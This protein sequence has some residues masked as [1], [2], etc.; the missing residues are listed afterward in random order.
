MIKS[1]VLEKV[2]KKF[3]SEWLALW[4]RSPYANFFNG[5]KWF[6]S[7]KEHFGGHY[8]VSAIYENKKLIGVIALFEKKV[9]GIRYYSV[10]PV[11]YTSGNPY[12]IDK[13][14][15][16]VVKKLLNNVVD[17]F[18]VVLGN[19]PESD[20]LLINNKF[21]NSFSIQESINH[22]LNINIT[23]EHRVVIRNKNK[24]IKRAREISSDLKL[25]CFT[26][27]YKEALPVVFKLDSGSRK[28]LKG[29]SAFS[30]LST[31]KF[32][33]TLAKYLKES[34]MVYVLYFEDKPIAYQIGFRVKD[35]FYCSQISSLAKF[36][37]YSL[38]R[39]LLIQ[40]I[41]D[42]G[43]RGVTKIDFGSGDDHVKRSLT[44]THTPLFRVI[45]GGK[46]PLVLAL[47]FLFRTKNT[48][49]NALSSHPSIYRLY[50][51]FIKRLKNLREF[52]YAKV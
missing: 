26:G 47:W 2:D 3:L 48:I 12:L 46:P 9:M 49:Y 5:P 34:L 18:I 25:V 38:G 19:V 11:D 45:I 35:T 8:I 37:K 31:Q 44:K 22:Y 27:V 10:A 28:S 21:N 50:K 40:V 20:T 39:V 52:Q 7:V 13:F 33:Q 43:N 42:L 15:E 32:Y 17:R 23:N 4:Q 14:S 41:E 1:I 6:M 24:L 29:Y 16:N 51:L 30:E 36:D